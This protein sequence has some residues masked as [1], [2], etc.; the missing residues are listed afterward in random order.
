ML[1]ARDCWKIGRGPFLEL[2]NDN[3]SDDMLVLLLLS[4]GYI[5]YET[6]TSGGQF[7]RFM[8]SSRHWC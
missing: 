6:V 4:R 7:N 3:Y 2:R 8:L 5:Q 1:S